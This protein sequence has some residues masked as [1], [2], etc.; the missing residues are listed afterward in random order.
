LQR[1]VTFV[2]TTRA[3]IANTT[4]APCD[5]ILENF[6]SHVTKPCSNQWD[7]GFS[8]KFFG[9][10]ILFDKHV[11]GLF[12]SHCSL[13][14]DLLL[15]NARFQKPNDM[16]AKCMSL[17]DFSCWP[18]QRCKD[19]RK[20]FSLF[21]SANASRQALGLACTSLQSWV[22]ASEVIKSHSGRSPTHPYPAPPACVG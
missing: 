16:T 3:K 10:V 21:Q 14:C 4:T 8:H 9:N 11:V 17:S 1:F 5:N 15:Q 12:C 19:V 6:A 22:G 18:Q 2:T 7:T 20:M 13:L